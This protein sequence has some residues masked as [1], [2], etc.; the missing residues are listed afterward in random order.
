ME[1]GMRLK[2][3]IVVHSYIYKLYI[4]YAYYAHSYRVG[5]YFDIKYGVFNFILSQT[6]SPQQAYYYPDKEG[7]QIN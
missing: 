2:I 3:L 4:I 1:A 7:I 5:W 6:I